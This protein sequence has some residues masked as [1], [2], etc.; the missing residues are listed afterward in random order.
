MNRVWFAEPLETVATWWRIARRDGVTLG[1]TTHDRDMWFEGVL[2]RA[3][4]GMIPSSIRRSGGLD[5]DSA[6]VSG[7]LTHDTVSSAD[8]AAGW[9]D[10]A[11]VCI[12]LIDWETGQHETLWVGTL[13]A[14]RE[15]G[16]AFC[17]E[18]TSR[19]S[20]LLQS[21][22]PRTSP[23]CRAQFCGPGCNLNPAFFTH[24]GLLDESDSESGEVM[25]TC[26]ASSENLVGGSLRWLDG[27][28]AGS[29]QRIA[30]IND[31]GAITLSPPLE[32]P[33]PAGLRATVREGCDHS[34]DTCATRF[35]NAANFRGEPFLPGNDLLA[36]YPAPS[37]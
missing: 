17:A 7:A 29:T 12:G 14:V 19:K 22:V 36:R 16:G 5:E 34:L 26:G 15:E 1:F 8:L 3:S 11:R 2:H 37:L 25:I 24:E 30:A 28:L 21:P 18:L 27:P 13:G 6:E 9:F 32:I 35:D 4:P 33:L 31:A 10:G 20:E 23:A